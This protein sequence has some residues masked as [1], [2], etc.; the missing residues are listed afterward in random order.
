LTQSDRIG[1]D[2]MWRRHGLAAG[3]ATFRGI[4]GNQKNDTWR[5]IMAVCLTERGCSWRRNLRRAGSVAKHLPGR[6]AGSLIIPAA[7]KFRF[8]NPAVAQCVAV[9]ICCTE[10]RDPLRLD[11][12]ILKI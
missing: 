10:W 8:F 11:H 2:L 7:E 1:A 6:K 3:R 9:A 4:S 5:T 12:R